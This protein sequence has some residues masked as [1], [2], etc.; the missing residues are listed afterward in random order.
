MDDKSDARIRNL[1]C[2]QTIVIKPRQGFLQ[3]GD[4]D[5]ERSRGHRHIGATFHQGDKAQHR[6]VGHA[7]KF[8]AGLGFD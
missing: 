2:P 8:L 6:S 3:L 1:E 5:P 4:F 7:G